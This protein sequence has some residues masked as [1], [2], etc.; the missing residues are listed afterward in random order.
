MKQFA[1]PSVL[2]LGVAGLHAC[3]PSSD[4]LNLTFKERA[5]VA[6]EKVARECDY[7]SLASA[8]L[9]AALH[10]ASA[11]AYL[12]QPG[13]AEGQA[14][15]YVKCLESEAAACTDQTAE[16]AE[17][18]ALRGTLTESAACFG[19]RQCASGKCVGGVFLLDAQA[20]LVSCGVCLPSA[21]LNDACD[22]DG[23]TATLPCGWGLQCVS[24][25]CT[26]RTA[27]TGAKVALGQSCDAHLRVC[28][29]GA[30]CE[31]GSCVAVPKLGEP[32]AGSARC[33]GGARCDVATSRCVDGDAAIAVGAPCHA[34]DACASGARCVLSPSSAVTGVCTKEK[35]VG[36]VCAS[37]SECAPGLFCGASKRCVDVTK[38]LSCPLK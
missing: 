20:S 8:R 33:Q 27:G 13:L 11:T 34:R 38:D 37:E 23:A 36:E 25:A 9:S 22:D 3:G 17:A 10:A 21:G 28:E 18:D 26:K 12:N 7:Q 15:I 30:I 35:V 14:E 29:S 31:S 2:L 16:C 1:I 32:C 19:D 5:Q 24:G 4:N 6:A